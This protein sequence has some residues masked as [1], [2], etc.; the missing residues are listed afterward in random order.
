MKFLSLFA[1]PLLA[2]GADAF[3]GQLVSYGQTQV[4]ST[5][6]FERLQLNDYWTGSTYAASILGGLDN[7]VDKKCS[8]T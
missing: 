3:K 4:T 1:T 5:K 8:L 6:A 7:C 2:I